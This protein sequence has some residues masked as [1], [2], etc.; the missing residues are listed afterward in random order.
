M[1]D[2]GGGE[3][4]PWDSVAGNTAFSQYSAER[5]RSGDSK[6]RW[7]PQQPPTLEQYYR[8]E[9][10]SRSQVSQESGGTNKAAAP[11]SKPPVSLTMAALEEKSTIMEA[12]PS[13]VFNRVWVMPAF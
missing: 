11:A 9:L 1:A 7:K 3:Q 8:G 6:R 4:V 13:A 10:P 2:S 12:T 5:Q